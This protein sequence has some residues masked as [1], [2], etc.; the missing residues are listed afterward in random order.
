MS[1]AEPESIAPPTVAGGCPLC[2]VATRVRFA[3]IMA[4]ETGE[5]FTVEECPRCGL[6]RTQP[7]PADLGPYYDSAYYGRR[8]GWTARLC[9]RRRLG[10]VRR[11]AGP[12]DGKSLL[13]YGCA[14][15][16]FLRE[17]RS[18][19]WAGVGIERHRP[20]DA[21][22]DVPIVAGLDDL[23]GQGPFDCVTFWHVLEHLDDPVGTLERV[24]RHL[25]PDGVV[26]AAVPNFASW[27]ARLTG[28]AWLAL[29][30]PR[31]LVHFTPRS[32]ARTFEAAE[33]AVGGIAF[34]EFEY[35]L[36]GWSQSVLNR[37]GGGR[38]EF[39]KA[40]SGRPN[41]GSTLRNAVQVG[42]G[43]GLSVLAVGPLVVENWLGRGGTMIVAARPS[44]AR[45]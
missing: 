9:H 14:E 1:T 27:Q 45:G 3:A 6:G 35:D 23:A 33:F 4:E 41:Q 15:G 39:F 25:K 7:V 17:A 40:V 26:L 22:G 12:G 38:N 19:G 32:L 36:I 31:H 42:A 44:Q 34:G 8:H 20:T 2:R 43:L 37:V 28:P 24:R 11:W 13:D 30:I 18:A 29:D 5:T 16:D 21:L 10:F